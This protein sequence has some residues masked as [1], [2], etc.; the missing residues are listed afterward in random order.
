MLE[1]KY[2][3]LL[4]KTFGA[5]PGYR[6][7]CISCGTEQHDLLR[8]RCAHCDGAVDAIH[9]LSITSFTDSHDPLRRYSALLPVRDPDVLRWLG[10]GNT[11]CIHARELGR[12]L[13]MDAL[14][15][16]DETSNPTRSTKDRVASVALARFAELGVREIALASTG[17]TSTSF[18]RAARLLGGFTLHIFVGRQ[19][20]HRLNYPDHPSTRTYV[21][22]SDFVSADISARRFAREAGIGLEGGFFNPSRREGLKLAYLEAFDDMPVAPEYVF[23]AVSSGMG[24]LGAYKG[25]M[26]Y[27]MLGKLPK[28]PAFTGVQQDTCDPMAHAFGNGDAT[29]D[30]RHRIPAPSGIAEAILR[31]DPAQSYPYINTVCRSTGGRITSVGT[32]EIRAARRLLKDLEG[33]DA[34]YSSATALAGMIAAR[35]RGEIAPDAPVLVVVTGADRP[36]APTP[37]RV[38]S[39]R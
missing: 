22:D 24:L 6:W 3:E 20:L 2:Q 29:F 36:H 39:A 17:N 33:L 38:E 4:D 1:L 35:D 14:Y 23:Q 11:A 21:V 16:K 19:F 30:A 32:E 18:A 27:R 7:C 25:A 15:L 10:E 13:G 5:G 31:G 37:R 8:N 28:M 9:D 34:C 12:R 26:E